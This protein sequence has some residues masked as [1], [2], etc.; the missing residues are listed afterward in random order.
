PGVPGELYVAGANLSRGYYGRP[1]LT[2]ER[3]VPD[4]LSGVPGARLYRTGDLARLGGDGLLHYA[5]RTDRQVKVRGHR[6]EPAEV[7]AVLDAHPAVREGVVEARPDGRG[8]LR[9]VGYVVPAD[10]VMDTDALRGHLRARLPEFMVP[11]AWVALEALPL[12][13][14]GKADRDALPEPPPP[15]ASAEHVE[16]RTSTERALAAAWAELLGVERVG[17]ADGFFELGGHSLLAMRL[18]SRVRAELGVELPL[19]AVFEAPRVAELASRVDAA[20]GELAD[21]AAEPAP[22]LVH[23][24]RDG[25]PAPLSFAQERMWFLERLLPG[26]PVY[27]L[28][29]RLRLRGPV[30]PEA[31]RRALE[32]VVHRHEPLRTTFSLRGGQ[33]VQVVHAPAGLELPLTDL[34]HLPREVAEAEA[35]A[36]SAREARRP[37]DL[38]RGPLLRAALLRIAPD[39]WL[40]LLDLHHIVSDGWSTGVLYRE[41][42]ALYRGFADGGDPH[43]PPLPVQYADYAAWQRRW[44][45]GARLEAQLAYWRDRLA[46][47]PVLD[48]PTDRPRPAQLSLRGGWVDFRLP[49]G[50]SAAVDALAKRENASVFMVL[51]AAFKALLAR[52]TGQADLV[53]GTPIAGRGRA[54]VEGLIGLFVNTL[55]LRTD[56]S[57]DPSFRQAVARVR[58][59]TLQAY[60]HQDVPFEKLVDELKVE[61][62]LSRHPLFQVSF[63]VVEGDDGAAAGFD[64]GAARAEPAEGDTATAKFDLTFAVVTGPDGYGGG[65]EYAEELFD[66]ETMRRFAGHF[67]ALVRAA[68]AEPDAPLSRLPSLLSADERRRVLEE[69]SHADHPYPDRPVHALFA[70]QAARTPDAVA[71]AYQGRAI[72]YAEL[73]ARANRIAHHLRARRVGP[74]V[75]VGVLAERAPETVAAVLGILKAGGGYLPLDPAYPAD[76]LRYMLGDAGVRVVIAPAGLPAGLPRD[77][78]PDLLDL[79]AEADAIAARPADDP[80]VP[81]APGSLAYLVYTSGSTGLPKGVLVPHRGVPNL[82]AAQ[83][84]RWGV[85]ARSRVLQF[86]SFSFDAAVSETFTA[87][88]TGAALVL[89]PREELVPGPALLETLRRERITKVTLPP[90]ALAVLEPDALPDLRTLIS[91]GEAVGPA[92]VARW[93]PGRAFHNA[94]GPTETTVG[95]A[96]AE[97]EPGDEIPPIGRPFDNVRCYVLDDA[98]Q[99]A[100]IGVPGEL[101]VG[102]PGVARGYHGRPGLTAERFVPDP[103]GAEPGARMY[104]TGDRVR[105]RGDGQLEFLGRLDEQVKIR[106]FRVE[107]GEVAALLAGRPGVADALVLARDGAG[108]RRLVAYVVAA[109]G[110]EAPR[111]G[112]LRDELKRRLPDYMVPSAIVVMDD[113][114]RTPNGKVDRAALP[115]PEPPAAAGQAPPQGEL[116]RA[117]AAVWQELLSLPGVGVHDN[118]FEVG[119][120]SL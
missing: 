96:S 33:P 24:A 15:A 66:S 64:L 7:E 43:L 27:N 2:A 102:G 85:D 75:P 63:S 32:A 81:I 53:V 115:E 69:W 89:A 51:A 23:A 110:A 44:L 57:G 26:S 119:G 104:R 70:E 28:P 108:G 98:L 10:G 55:A 12:T 4:P 3:F 61:R 82:A 120:H 21:E 62:S 30:D 1:A 90:S 58:E 5:G 47:A 107:P 59:T 118:F 34:A 67:A 52:Y 41:L 83:V 73:D 105:W 38:E 117:M 25:E 6:I 65:V 72:T 20:R 78:V 49:A 80:R 100:P 74:D 46:G 93:A 76:R 37:F 92:V 14:N 39:E 77:D 16:P 116:E 113:F 86:A 22:P 97:C 31:L 112:V 114:P 106:G 109:E 11:D 99:P 71:L 13:P 48:L 68:V 88:T 94:Y 101:C 54:E 42:A 40:L 84:R 8:G 111:P 91:A 103:Y 29:L 56:L 9:L 79:R 50:V 95:A 19:R 45:S 18:V 36:V 60:A 35:E 87:L 17:A